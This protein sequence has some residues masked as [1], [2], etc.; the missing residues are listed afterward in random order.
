MLMETLD[1]KA[2]EL[3]VQEQPIYTPP[4]PDYTIP[5][6]DSQ[7]S[8][9]VVAVVAT[10]LLFVVGLGVAKLINKKKRS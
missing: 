3:G 4:F 2:E 9:L 5:G 6:L 7:W 8:A 1:L 10:L